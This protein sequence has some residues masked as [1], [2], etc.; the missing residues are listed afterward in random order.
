LDEHTGAAKVG[1]TVADLNEINRAAG[2]IKVEGARY[3]E[4][5]EH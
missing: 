5:L 4:K 2:K 3:P 1:L